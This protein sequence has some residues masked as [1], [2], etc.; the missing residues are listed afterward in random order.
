MRPPARQPALIQSATPP[1]SA[2]MQRAPTPA[3]HIGSL[4]RLRPAH[5]HRDSWPLWQA[6][7]HPHG[8]ALA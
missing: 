1:A 7:R 4:A 8:L 2:V 6:S 5:R 3:L